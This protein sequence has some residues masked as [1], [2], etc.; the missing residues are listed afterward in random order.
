MYNKA[1]AKDAT[2]S[3]IIDADLK[4]A[5]TSLAKSRGMKLRSL[6]EY[7]LREQLEDLLDV[8]VYQQRLNEETAGVREVEAY[9]KNLR[10]K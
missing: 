10:R 3:T 2:L 4:R 6:I 8:S 9:F 7:A 1:M 5:V